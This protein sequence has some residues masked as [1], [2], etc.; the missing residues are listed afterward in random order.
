MPPQK[1]LP[2]R[3]PSSASGITML[4]PGHSRADHRHSGK[5]GGWMLLFFSMACLGGGLLEAPQPLLVSSEQ[6]MVAV[7]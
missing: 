4:V 2:G 5:V 7:L 3:A 1:S 6:C